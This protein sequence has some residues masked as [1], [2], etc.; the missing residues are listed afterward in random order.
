MLNELLRCLQQCNSVYSQQTMRSNW[1]VSCDSPTHSSI[2]MWEGSSQL[3]EK[4]VTNVEL[5]L[6]KSLLLVESLS[7]L[8]HFITT[9]ISIITLSL[10]LLVLLS[11]SSPAPALQ[12]LSLSLS[13]LYFSS[14]QYC[15]YHHHYHS[16]D[17]IGQYHQGMW[18]GATT[19]LRCF[20]K[21]HSV[22]F[23]FIHFCFSKCTAEVI[24]VNS[25]SAQFLC[26]LG[27]KVMVVFVGAE[28]KLS[29]TEKQVAW[30]IS[31]LL[32]LA[33]NTGHLPHSGKSNYIIAHPFI[34][35]MFCLLVPLVVY[36]SATQKRTSLLRK[37]SVLL[38]WERCCRTKLLSY[39][40][41]V[42]WYQANQS[43]H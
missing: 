22:H 5:H 16:G 28:L 29:T 36:A 20:A 18:T 31:G 27:S 14:Y 1:H 17:N 33:E 7:S 26:S 15:Y 24:H 40:V 42:Y 23:W 9:I 8:H 25:M 35:L 11:S 30:A 3:S 13:W 21:F 2:A 34:W 6:L 32:H 12:L 43:K 37:C 4:N 10:L 19:F 41:T 39:P 38:H